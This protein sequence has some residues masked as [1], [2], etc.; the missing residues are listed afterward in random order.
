MGQHQKRGSRPRVGRIAAGVARL[1]VEVLG[2]A[3]LH[4]ELAEL[5]RNLVCERILAARTQSL[6]RDESGRSPDRP[7]PV[8]V[9]MVV[10]AVDGLRGESPIGDETLGLDVGNHLRAALLGEALPED[11]RQARDERERVAVEAAV[12]QT[13]YARRAVFVEEDLHRRVE[14]LLRARGPLHGLRVPAQ[15]LRDVGETLHL[16]NEE[17]LEVGRFERRTIHADCSGVVPAGVAAVKIFS[18]AVVVEVA[19]REPPVRPLADEVVGDLQFVLRK[20]LHRAQLREHPAVYGRLDGEP[21]DLLV[22][23]HVGHHAL[24]SNEVEHAAE[25]LPRGILVVVAEAERVDRVVPAPRLVHPV[26]A[27]Q[28]HRTPEHPARTRDG[29]PEEN[30]R[31][32]SR[33]LKLLRHGGKR[34]VH[35]L[36]ARLLARDSFRERPLHLVAVPVARVDVEERHLDA[37]L[38]RM[39]A[40][41]VA[42]VRIAHA[43][44][45]VHQDAVRVEVHVV[46]GASERR[47]EVVLLARELV[48]EAD[49]HL[50]RLRAHEHHVRTQIRK[51]DRALIRL[52]LQPSSAHHAL[53][54]L[55]VLTADG[56]HE[57]AEILP[58]R[59][60]DVAQPEARIGV[61]HVPPLLAPAYSQERPRHAVRE[62]GVTH[63]HRLG[64]S[65][66]GTRDH[67]K[68]GN[69]STAARGLFL[70]SFAHNLFPYLYGFALHSSATHEKPRKCTTSPP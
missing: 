40:H 62:A 3:R 17:R 48:L 30:R 61:E 31:L 5:E 55:H 27:H 9:G 35:P 41:G 60:A 68:C 44:A 69:R 28:H 38:R 58:P 64:K 65:Q 11:H 19:A 21:E 37:V 2:E 66:H 45:R 26:V 23:D 8:A 54:H 12:A 1:R 32:V 4:Y 7:L 15:R 53:R 70:N 51:L 14:H 52:R 43:Y 16:E 22:R 46:D 6:H 24:W 25:L 56:R 39:D 49:V 29:R 63:L 34:G 59:G 33:P 42:A 57:A 36:E 50:R 18:E 20:L 67:S 13:P 10:S 47:G